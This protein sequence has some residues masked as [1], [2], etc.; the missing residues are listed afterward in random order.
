MNVLIS[1]QCHS[2]YHWEISFVGK[3]QE[4]MGDISLATKVSCGSRNLH[5]AFGD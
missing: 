5:Q 3:T 1:L 4:G 2:K